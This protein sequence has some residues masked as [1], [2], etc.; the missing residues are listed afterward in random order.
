MTDLHRRLLVAT[1]IGL[2]A[3]ALTFAGH[4]P[5]GIRTDF[6][7]LWIAGHA[8]THGQD[9]FAA[10]RA[11]ASRPPGYDLLYPATA[12][13][14]TA[15]F[16]IWPRAACLALWTGLGFG[17][18][19]Y[20]VTRS[21]WWGLLSLAS[22][23]ALHAFFSVQWSPVLVASATLPWLAFLW[24]A[25]PSVGAALFA[26]YPSRRL[27]VA[28][29]LV[30]L[31]TFVVFPGWVAEWRAALGTRHHLIPLFLR[32][33]GWL[34]LLAWLRWRHPEGRLLGALA[35]VPHTLMPYDLLTLAVLL[36]TRLEWIG[37]T[38]LAWASYLAVRTWAWIPP[39]RD[40][41]ASIVA[42]WPY[43]LTLCYLPALALVLARPSRGTEATPAG[44]QEPVGTA[45][46]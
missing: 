15:P 12:F 37:A 25:K 31:A 10:A 45:S 6:D 26:A 39:S 41:D 35:I 3:A 23:F 32:P 8:W 43:W 4:Y 14:L 38:V 17:T 27:L 1:F 36:R 46:V 22:P 13:L 9:P 30:S 42:A 40:H 5:T 34:L 18:M 20:A 7:A 28:G 19:T 33:G 29:L 21:T 16:T 2:L 24:I 44:S 11:Y